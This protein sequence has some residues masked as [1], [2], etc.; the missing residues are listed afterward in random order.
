MA[1]EHPTRVNIRGL[2]TYIFSTK[3]NEVL[4]FIKEN[5]LARWMRK[6]TGHEERDGALLID[7]QGVAFRTCMMVEGVR[8][9]AYTTR[10][11][12]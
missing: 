3:V 11:N 1:K 9:I 6:V 5:V 8:T 10:L 12:V 4:A 2:I 7:L